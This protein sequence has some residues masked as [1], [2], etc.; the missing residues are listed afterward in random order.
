MMDLSVAMHG[1]QNH[2]TPDQG[3]EDCGIIGGALCKADTRRESGASA[4]CDEAVPTKLPENPS[5][6]ATKKHVVVS[7]LVGVAIVIRL[8]R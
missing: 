4:P 7:L 6:S 5:L 1:R 3:I 8:H 2:T